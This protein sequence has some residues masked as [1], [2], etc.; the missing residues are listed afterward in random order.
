MQSIQ[1]GSGDAQQSDERQD[2][3]HRT[4]SSGAGDSPGG[5]GDD[6]PG[7]QSEQSQADANNNP[8]GIGERQFEPVNV[9]RRIGGDANGDN[10][11]Q[12]PADPNAPVQEGNFSE[13]PNG[14]VTVPYNQVFSD[15]ANAANRALDSD[16]VP[17]GLRDVVRDYFT[18]LEP[19]N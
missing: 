12:L 3:H 4:Q 15:Y 17:L 2:Q 19:G 18:S 11:I 1:N 8:D 5:A 7:V 14:Q 13:N 6:N 10:N 16:Y 9:P